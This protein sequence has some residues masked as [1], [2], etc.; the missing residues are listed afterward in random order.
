MPDLVDF[1]TAQQAEPHSCWACA[2]RMIINYYTGVETYASDQALANAWGATQDPVL[3]NVDI[4][5]ARSASAVL[6]DL[7]YA[8]NTDDAPVPTAD[9]IT[10]AINDGTPLLSNVA[11]NNPHGV[12][13]IDG[14]GEHW[15]VITGINDGQL[16]VFDP[17][18]GVIGNEAYNAA[19][20][21]DGVYWQNTSYVDNH[22]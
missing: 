2:S 14:G 4:D 19:T 5:V 18:T 11:L 7:G 10:E 1:P 8:N 15:V 6:I 17:D 21:Q 3:D 12:P 20:Y 22:N 13:V 16:S 9:E